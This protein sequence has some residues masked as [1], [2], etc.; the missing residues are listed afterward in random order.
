MLRSTRRIRRFIAGR[1]VGCGLSVVV[2]ACSKDTTA[3]LTPSLVTVT[4]GAN[5]SGTVNATLTQPIAVLVTDSNG[6]PVSGVAVTFTPNTNAGSVSSAQA[7]TD[8]AGLA[9]VNWKIGTAAGLDS[10]TVSIASESAIVTAI[11]TADVAAQ[12]TVVSGNSQVAPADSTLGAPLSV[13]VTDQ[14]GNPVAGVTVNWSS[15]DGGILAN[16][17]TVTDANGL[18]QDTLTLGERGTDDVS[19]SVIVGTLPL[20]AMFTEQAQ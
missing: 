12:V 15:D 3:P 7:T 10:M 8:N 2:A 1:V 9:Q 5:Q 6:R 17:T 11:G 13:K 16:T 18:A 4:S 19:V 14:Y 20:S